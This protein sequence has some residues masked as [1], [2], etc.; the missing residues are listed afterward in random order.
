MRSLPLRPERRSSRKAV[1]RRSFARA[2]RLVPHAPLSLL[3]VALALAIALVPACR[4]SSSAPEAAAPSAFAA[5]AAPA[6][7]A[8]GHRAT[9]T[10]KLEPWSCGTIARMHTLGG[11]YLASQ[12]KASDL[13]L[14][15]DGGIETVINLRHPTEPIGFDER[16]AVAALG[17]H[18]VTL[19]FGKPDELTDELL[20]RIREHLNREPRPL[21]LHCA[22]ANRVGAVWMA[23]RAL[24]GGLSIDE[25]AAEAKTVGLKTLELEAK[26][27]DYVAR[28]CGG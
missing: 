1:L 13:E 7:G 6:G 15:R 24:D 10:G 5:P 19:P 16:A 27:R 25:A 17:L 11:I 3:A 14:A 4:S 12:P 26:V 2:A 18:Y 9:V 28:R 8:A 20:D 23:W 22:S 21:L